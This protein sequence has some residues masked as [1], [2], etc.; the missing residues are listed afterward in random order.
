MCPFALWAP[1]TPLPPQ[2]PWGCWPVSRLHLYLRL[3][4]SYYTTS[5]DLYKPCNTRK[6]EYSPHFTDEHNTSSKNV[7]THLV[8]GRA[9]NQSWGLPAAGTRFS[10]RRAPD[11]YHW[12][13]AFSNKKR[14]TKRERK[15][16]P[17]TQ[18]ADSSEGLVRSA[19]TKAGPIPPFSLPPSLPT[20]QRNLINPLGLTS[21]NFLISY[22]YKLHLFLL[23]HQAQP[24]PPEKKLGQFSE[25]LIYCNFWK[26]DRTEERQAWNFNSSCSRCRHLCWTGEKGNRE[27]NKKG[28]VPDL[29]RAAR[30]HA[31]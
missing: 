7:V 4:H 20:S 24:T 14:W 21:F 10:P 12:V 25:P 15:R 30:H 29:S 31:C 23:S 26:S 22:I 17:D 18:R 3:W 13:A 27:W 2:G 6:V 9:R 1:D 5:V 8:S 28:K 16:S 19:P 11:C